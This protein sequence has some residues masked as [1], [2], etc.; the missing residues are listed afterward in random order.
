MY[1]TIDW[2]LVHVTT[3]THL[4]GWKET[5]WP[6]LPQLLRGPTE[7][8]E[9]VHK[10]E[11]HL[12]GR[13]HSGE[14]A[15]WVPT[16]SLWLCVQATRRSCSEAV[17]AHRAG[18]GHEGNCLGLV[19][20]H[21]VVLCNAIQSVY[22]K[23]T[24]YCVY[25]CMCRGCYVIWLC[26]HWHTCWFSIR[27]VITS[28]CMHACTQ[29]L[30]RVQIIGYISD[31]STFLHQAYDSAGSIKPELQAVQ[32]KVQ[33]VSIDDIIH[34]SIPSYSTSLAIVTTSLLYHNPHS[35]ETHT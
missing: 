30:F 4:T 21:W 5:F 27:C 10:E 19:R 1:H 24:L 33:I 22:V 7:A 29:F 31:V 35:W 32:F 20:K 11:G 8:P 25:M 14:R 13:L 2:V 17:W 9:Y 3:H 34:V 26:V 18:K 28:N 23:F 15:R 12:W 6:L 16:V